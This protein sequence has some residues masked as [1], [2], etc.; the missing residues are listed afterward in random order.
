LRAIRN[1]SCIQPLLIAAEDDD[2]K[3]RSLAL[4]SL[5]ELPVQNNQEVYAA[6]AKAL[7]EGEPEVQYHAAAVLGRVGDKKAVELLGK[8]LND[9]IQRDNVRQEAARALGLIG[10]EAAVKHLV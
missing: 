6:A 8:K 9:S 3:V 7:Q 1:E 2:K 5:S 4:L 10:G